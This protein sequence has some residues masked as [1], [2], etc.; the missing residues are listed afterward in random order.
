MTLDDATGTL[1]KDSEVLLILIR[2]EYVM[3]KLETE[4]EEILA[5]FSMFY[6]ILFYFMKFVVM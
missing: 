4:S 1:M 2:F 5:Y 3:D 6:F